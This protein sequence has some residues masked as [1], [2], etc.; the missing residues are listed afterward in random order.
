MIG[1]LY[2][3]NANRNPYFKAFTT[4]VIV[5]N[6][7]YNPGS[8]AVQLNYANSEW[9]GSDIIPQNCR[10]TVVGNVLIQGVDTRSG[11]AMVST[12]GDAYLEDN[13]AEELTGNAVTLSSGDVRILDE[14]HCI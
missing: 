11:L 3:H 13:I 7:I 5:N 12:K 1:N 9:Q 14:K 2:A 4:G 8:R 10:V 6:V